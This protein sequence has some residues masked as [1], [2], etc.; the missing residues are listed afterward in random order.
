VLAGA[1][2]AGAAVIQPPAILGFV[3]NGAAVAHEG[4]R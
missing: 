1:A 4:D 2:V 3:H